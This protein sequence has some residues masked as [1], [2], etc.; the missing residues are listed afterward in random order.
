M[1]NQAEYKLGAVVIGVGVMMG[2]VVVG[3]RR[4]ILELPKETN[5]KICDLLNREYPNSKDLDKFIFK[6]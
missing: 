1:S 4:Y 6:Q 3:C 5:D 2:D